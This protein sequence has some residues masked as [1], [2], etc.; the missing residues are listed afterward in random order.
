[1]SK[2][3]TRKTPSP[4]SIP[5]QSAKISSSYLLHPALLDGAL[6][7]LF[8]LLGDRQHQMQG[9]GFLPWRFGRVRLA[10]P[11]GRVPRQ[12]KLRLTRIGVRSI[13]A[14]IVLSN[15]SGDIIAELADCWFRR[16]ELTRQRPVDERALRIDLI[17]AP[18][19][20]PGPPRGLADLPATLSRLAAVQKPSPLRQEQALLLDALIGSV[21]FQSLAKLVEPGRFFAVSE[22]AE[23]GS[24]RARFDWHRR[25]FATVAQAVRCRERD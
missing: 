12:A 8:A 22:L 4:T 24:D 5:R 6:Q 18:L 23:V 15:D 20:E 13:S 1:M 3:P 7:G 19:L 25:V 2:S 14:D 16:V 10:A 11:F 17:P 21:T 9:V